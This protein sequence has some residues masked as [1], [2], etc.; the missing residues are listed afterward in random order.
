MNGKNDELVLK[1]A[2]T[3]SCPKQEFFVH[4]L[5]YLVGDYVNAGMR[6]QTKG[7][8]INALLD[9]VDSR[10]S[11]EVEV[12]RARTLAALNGGESIDPTEWL[13]FGM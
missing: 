9:R 11:S 2:N 3:E 12:W 5:Y 10:S 6:D 1:L 7:Q 4:C 8:R 13:H